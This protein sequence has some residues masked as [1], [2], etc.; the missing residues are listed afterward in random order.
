MCTACYGLGMTDERSLDLRRVTTATAVVIAVVAAAV[1]VFVLRDILLLL[2]LG[3]VVGAA[4]QPWH[5]RLG[6]VGVPRGLAVLLIYVV[7]AS[8]LFVVAVVVGP[9]V[10]DG[11]TNFIA[12]L[13]ERYASL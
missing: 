11:V 13:P 4:L 9:P 5:L 8:A 7:L 12:A 6:A 3:I 2:F 10:A 1:L